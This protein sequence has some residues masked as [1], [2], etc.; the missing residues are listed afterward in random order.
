MNRVLV[1]DNVVVS[2]HVEI[3]EAA[4]ASL[5]MFN[6]EPT[7]VLQVRIGG[8]PVLITILEGLLCNRYQH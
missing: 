3:S 5:Q 7:A 1:V 6:V 4:A 8:M 2:A